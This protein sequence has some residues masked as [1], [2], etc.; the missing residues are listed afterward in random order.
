MLKQRLQHKLLQKL[1]PQQIQLMKLLQVPTVELEQRIKEEIEENPALEEGAELE[2]A[3]NELE[4]DDKFDGD[5]SESRD[6]D[7]FDINDY[8]DDDI[9]AYKTHSNNSSSENDEKAI[10]LSGG[11]TFQ[12]LL[13]DQIGLRIADKKELTIARTIIGNLDDGGYLRREII[14]LVDDLAFSQ[15]VICDEE[16]VKSVLKKVQNLE[17]AGVGARNLQECLLLQLRRKDQM[18]IEQKTAEVVLEK[19]FEEFT[20]KHYNK[21]VKKLEIVYF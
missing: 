1:S 16:E 7:E 9:P 17:P 11:K 12:E 18:S 8:L 14:N 4:Q 5:D 6:S 3:Q 21:I 10:P 2:D 20:K 13:D 15:N 19:F